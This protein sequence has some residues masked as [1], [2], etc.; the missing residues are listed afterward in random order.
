MDGNE[1]SV[2]PK[3]FIPTSGCLICGCEQSDSRK[4]TKLDGKVT[5]LCK[6]ICKLLDLPISSIDVTNEYICNDIC[7]RDIKRL[8][9]LRENE[10]TQLLQFKEKFWSVKRFKRGV[11]SEASLSP[12]VTAPSKS[13]RRDIK[14]VPKTL[15]F[16]KQELPLVFP[17]PA[18]NLSSTENVVSTQ[19]DGKI[20]KVQV[21][22]YLYKTCFVIKLDNQKDQKPRFS[23][24]MFSRYM[25]LLC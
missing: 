3:K 17:L 6:R 15:N 24:Y 20:C 10:E 13:L 18:V 23:R 8:E 2:T 12:R 25:C 14:I 11:P 5:D 21:S 22:A 9:K 7:Y 16:E 4:K 19:C 1:K